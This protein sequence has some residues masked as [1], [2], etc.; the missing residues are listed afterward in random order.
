M[1]RMTHLILV[2]TGL[3]LVV[4]A[5]AAAQRSG[6]NR[7]YMDTTCSPC[8]D[9]F[10]Y[11]NG[12]WLADVE[13]PPAY[14][15]AG[16]DLEMILRNQETLHRILE[17]S[18][19]NVEREKDATVQKV[20]WLY[21]VLMD[22]VRADREGLAPI[23]EDLKRVEALRTS[24]EVGGEFAWAAAHGRFAPVILGQEP[25]PKNSRV[26]IAQLRQGGLGLPDR[27][28]YFRTDPKSDTLRR[29]YV[30]HVAR[31]FVMQ[32]REPARARTEA[33]RMF[34]IETALAESSLSAEEQRDPERLYHK[35]TVA[36]LQRLCPA[37][38]WVAFFAA[39][40]LK[41]LARPTATLDVSCPA[42]VRQLGALLRERPIEDWRA[43]LRYHTVRGA[44]YWL[45]QAAYGE[46]FSFNSRLSGQK[47]PPPRWRR[48]AG[49][50]DGAMGEAIGKA[51]VAT[52][53]PP[54][55]KARMNELVDNLR[56]ALKE[57]IRTRPWMSEA[58]KKQ[59]LAKLA[60][61]TQ[62]IGY[63]DTWRDYSALV[64]DPKQPAAVNLRRAQEFEQ[65]RQLAKIGRPVDRAEWQM[66]AS[67]VNAYYDP[68]TGDIC[69]PA[70]ILSPPAFDPKADDA[71]NYGAIGA[72]IGHELSHAFDDQG[73][74]YDEKGNL[75]DWWTPEDTREFEARSQR[76]IEQFN[77][78]LVV[79]TL[80]A[81]GRLT[82]GENIGDLG[83]L[84]IA[85]HAWQLS[86]RGKPRPAPIDGFAP[87][88]RFFLS[89]AEYWRQAWRPE[90]ARMVT[91]TDPH[92][93][94][95]WRV[96]G[97]LANLPEFAKAFG[98]HAGDPMVLSEEKRTEIW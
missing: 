43:Y 50:L 13:I 5:L 36:E 70:G 10:Q 78:Y 25:D 2:L 20:G 6:P 48:A 23:A 83:G 18:A 45:G 38:D 93:Y 59:A 37:V 49:A 32:G 98:C 65:Q 61:F 15:F 82:L 71:V 96:I 88:Q 62:K 22:S 12:T 8:R 34:G 92:S 53:F 58:T 60:S 77:G 55:S 39:A 41:P 75:R 91:L 67:T 86:L 14:P 19:A 51:F 89:W 4:P 57:R 72:V 90:F 69:F 79:D 63:P 73:R 16:A 29:E 52:E 11:A 35:M 40:G 87:E 30:A 44:M 54:S 24:A 80:H 64:I 3:A 31:V 28:Y 33:E 9:F 21:R 7:A 81:N 42:F 95:K 84:A 27:D 76:L 1:N 46:M 85:H 26:A 47:T 74:K 68:S 97:P 17:R 94:P 66:T 56:A